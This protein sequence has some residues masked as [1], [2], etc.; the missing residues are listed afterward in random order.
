MP[1]TE[2]AGNLAPNM[3]TFI[4]A[5]T[6]ALIMAGTAIKYMANAG[7]NERLIKKHRSKS[8][9]QKDSRIKKT[10]IVTSDETGLPIERSVPKH[11][12]GEMYGTVNR[13]WRVGFPFIRAYNQVSLTQKNSRI[14]DFN[15][16]AYVDER[17]RKK[18]LISAHVN[19]TIVDEPYAMNRATFDFLPDEHQQTIAN[20]CGSGLREVAKNMHELA[21]QDEE[22]LSAGLFAVRAIQLLEIAGVR[23]T[24]VQ[25]NNA[26]VTDAQLLSDGSSGSGP[27]NLQKLGATDLELHVD[28]NLRAVN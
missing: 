24:G 1:F 15:V 9:R 27:S 7:E 19:Y 16:M 3:S 6:G 25:L 10:I 28:T 22:I 4:P 12:K 8:T 14:E 11:L 21:M 20:I 23:L 2:V 5:T 13:G 26:I 18:H 17:Q